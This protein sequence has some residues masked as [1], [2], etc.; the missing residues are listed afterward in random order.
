MR[1][2]IPLS[3]N[4]KAFVLE[5][6]LQFSQIK[7][8]FDLCIIS[9]PSDLY[10][11]ADAPVS[12]LPLGAIIQSLKVGNTNIVQGFPEQSQYESYNAPY[13]GE[14]IGRVA[15]RLKAAQLDSVN[16]GKT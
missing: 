2:Q 16:G 3:C 4:A 6:E 13:F 14:T 10:T 8:A 7:P 1:G 9:S 12:F 15:N 5:K 11:M